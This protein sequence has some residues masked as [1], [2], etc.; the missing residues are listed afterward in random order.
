MAA[1]IE[2]IKAARLRPL[3]VTTTARATLLPDVPAL[4]EFLPSYEA[5]I[6]VGIS[7]PHGTAPEIINKLN[8]EI[9]IGLA[10]PKITRRIAELGDVPLALSTADFAR[11]VADETEKWAK[12]IRT[13][14]IKP[15]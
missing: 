1:S 13:A 12:V 9:N 7:A 10:D 4:A 14:N 5:S 6:Y 11:L 15:E 2:Y 8:Q 3:A